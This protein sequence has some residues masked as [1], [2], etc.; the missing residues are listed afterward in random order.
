MNQ[1]STRSPFA[2][3]SLLAGSLLLAGWGG[4][5]G[6]VPR[7]VEKVGELPQDVEKVG[8]VPQDGEKVGESFEAIVGGTPAANG[9][10]PWTVAVLRSG[11]FTCGGALIATNKVLTAAS[12]VYGSESSPATFSVRY[13][14]KTLT[15][16][17][18]ITVSKI[19]R[20]ASYNS[21]T[22]DYDVAV[23]TLASAFTPGTNAAVI[24]V[25]S[26]EP[27][28]GTVATVAGW[29]RTSGGGAV[30]NTLLKADLNIVARATCQSTYGSLNSITARMLCAN[31]QNRG[32]CGGDQGGPLMIAVDGKYQLVGIM[33]WGVSGCL[34]TY[35]SVFSNVVNLRS[36]IVSQ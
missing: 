23:L 14:S 35:P 21:S 1:S 13:N 11:S 2:L 7:D 19:S 22:I 29:G 4:E 5:P 31:A 20:H 16:G 36:W 25:A 24:Q 26:S 34:T 10:A 6:V 32:M 27:T 30:S 9:E 28:S 17:S 3:L 8:Q 12:C 33:S 18:T 15:G